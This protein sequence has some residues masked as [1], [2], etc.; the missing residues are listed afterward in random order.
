MEEG[1]E[2]GGGDGKGSPR[3]DEEG[4]EKGEEAAE[5]HTGTIGEKG[6]DVAVFDDQ[7]KEDPAINGAKGS[8]DHAEFWPREKGET[9]HELSRSFLHGEDGEKA[10]K[11]NEHAEPFTTVHFFAEVEVGEEGG[12]EGG[13]AIDKASF[14]S[15]EVLQAPKFKG[16]G[17][18]NAKEGEEAYRKNLF[19]GQLE[20]GAILESHEAKE[21]EASEEH[22]GCREKER[23]AVF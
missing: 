5:K 10:T 6:G 2:A 15:G 17:E 16:V 21:E 23:G 14:R 20:G 4:V 22:A 7:A 3:F 18:V 13:E 8:T 19:R 12:K 9:G 1:E 11:T